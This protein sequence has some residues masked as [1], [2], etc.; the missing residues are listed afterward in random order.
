MFIENITMKYYKSTTNGRI[1]IP[2]ELR[3]KLNLQPGRKVKFEE[4]E[5]GI[6]MISLLTTDEIEVDIGFLKVKEKSLL[7]ALMEEKKKERDLCTAHFTQ[8]SFLNFLI[9]LKSLLVNLR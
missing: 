9:L 7:K 3:K 8:V 1:T 6:L 4:T 2:I 5:D